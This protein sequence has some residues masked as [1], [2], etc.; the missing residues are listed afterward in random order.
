MPFRMSPGDAWPLG[1]NYDGIGTNFCVFSQI[2]ETVEVC[3]FADDG[4]EE[5]YRLP[6]SDAYCWHGFLEGVRPGQRYGLRVHGPFD[7]QS[8]LRCNP[9]K[10][11]LDPYAK[12]VDGSVKW[13]QEVF[14]YPLGTDDLH[15][16][17]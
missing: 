14:P 7:P 8:G 11:L 3:L 2:A 1:A 12:A 5:R 15:L 6:E 13:G 16:D 17:E 9:A 10:L 4:T